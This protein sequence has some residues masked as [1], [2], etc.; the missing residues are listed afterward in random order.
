MPDD[1]W[2]SYKNALKTR[3]KDMVKPTRNLRKMSTLLYKDDI[4]QYLMEFQVFNN[5]VRLG[6]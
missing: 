5:V 3:F 1:L 2:K 4:T 6:G